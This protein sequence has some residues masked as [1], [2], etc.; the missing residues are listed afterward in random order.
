MRQ[1]HRLL[2]YSRA[3]GVVWYYVRDEHTWQRIYVGMFLRGVKAGRINGGR[4][5]NYESI[6][7][8]ESVL[9]MLT[10]LKAEAV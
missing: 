1:R 6:E 8:F 9:R 5:V 2:R 10:G 3:K 4:S 7:Q